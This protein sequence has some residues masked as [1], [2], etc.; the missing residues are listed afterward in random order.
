[1]GACVIFSSYYSVLFDIKRG[2]GR[3]KR[4]PL[5][6]NNFLGD[7]K[8]FVGKFLTAIKLGGRGGKAL[9]TLP[10]RKEL[11]FCGSPYFFI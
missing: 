2:G 6:K 5:R 3:I 7:L 8:K 9:M 10:L 1:M 11:F 4:L